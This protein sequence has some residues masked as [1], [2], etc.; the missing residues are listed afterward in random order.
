MQQNVD[1]VYKIRHLEEWMLPFQRE[2]GD[3]ISK[4]PKEWESD[5]DPCLLWCRTPEK[6][7]LF[8]PCPLFLQRQHADGSEDP[9]GEKIPGP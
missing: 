3:Y 6:A 1:L 9:G 2:T 5:S 8:A 4:V 7:F